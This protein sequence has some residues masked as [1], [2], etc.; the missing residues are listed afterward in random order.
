MLI[1]YSSHE[2]KF[3]YLFYTWLKM[4]WEY[5]KNRVYIHVYI[6]LYLLSIFIHITISV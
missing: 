1:F 6:L 4:V 2:K 3:K 5:L